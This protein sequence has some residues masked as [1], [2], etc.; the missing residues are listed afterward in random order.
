MDTRQCCNPSCKR[1]VTRQEK[2]IYRTA[3]NNIITDIIYFC[4]C[5][6]IEDLFKEMIFKSKLKCGG[7]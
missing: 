2:I 1:R 5:C 6:K 4:D 3:S 7:W